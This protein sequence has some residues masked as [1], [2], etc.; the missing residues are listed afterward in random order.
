MR[1]RFLATAQYRRLELVSA[2]EAATSDEILAHLEPPGTLNKHQQVAITATE[3][4]LRRAED[5]P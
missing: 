2:R 3:R 1:A 5:K 4:S